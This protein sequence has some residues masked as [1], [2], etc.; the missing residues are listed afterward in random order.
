MRELLYIFIDESGNFD[1]SVKGTSYFTFSALITN[2]PLKYD[3]DI[4]N[5]ILKILTK[6]EIP[7]LKYEYL[8]QFSIKHFHATEDKQSIRDLF[9][10]LINSMDN[11]TLN[12]IIIEKRKTNPALYDPEKFYTKFL[13]SLMAYV[14]QAYQFDELCIFVDGCAVTRNKD[15]F[16]KGIVKELHYRNPWAKFEIYFPPSSTFSC[17][18]IVDYLNWAIFRKWE[19]EDLRS[20]DQIKH[21]LQ[22]RERDIFK[23]G[24]IYYY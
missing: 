12:S 16:K 9:I 1:F 13:G 8:D 4:N 11:I 17:L 6:Q 19:K 5:L 2:T 20:Y 10:K 22:S 21:L 15:A 23:D 7:N 14:F 18:Q 3:Y 24:K